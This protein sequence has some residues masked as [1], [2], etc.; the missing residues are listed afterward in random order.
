MQLV[1]VAV[2]SWTVG[3]GGPAGAPPI[4]L[5]SSL[6]NGTPC[7]VRIFTLGAF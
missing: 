6:V 5:L 2:V 7:A 3:P 4:I 1:A